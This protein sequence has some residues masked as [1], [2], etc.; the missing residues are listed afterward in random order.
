MVAW[1]QESYSENLYNRMIYSTIPLKTK[2][3]N[4]PHPPLWI[5][6]SDSHTCARTHWRWDC[7]LNQF[8]KSTTAVW[9]LSRI[10]GCPL[11]A[12]DSQWWL[13]HCCYLGSNP[14]TCRTGK[15]TRKIGGDH[16]RTATYQWGGKTRCSQVIISPCLQLSS[17]YIYIAKLCVYG[18]SI[19]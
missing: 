10:Y 3:Y 16:A 9:R 19:S 6:N 13:L 7:G 17:P 12:A 18:S 5:L 11:N 4:H 1:K 2:F 8:N 15:S 14:A